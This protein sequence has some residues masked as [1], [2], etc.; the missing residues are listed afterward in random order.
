MQRPTP[1]GKQ[2]GSPVSEVR[3]PTADVGEA[4][5]RATTN[6]HDLEGLTRPLL[7]ALAKLGSFESTYLTVFDWERREQEV[8]VVHSVGKIQVEEGMRVAIPQS[9]S[10]EA[11]PGVT[12][13]PVDL[14]KTSPDSWVA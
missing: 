11:L 14:S 12:R 10:Q 3:F 1:T 5:L 8:R 7:E 6:G 9:L 4:L 13:S 2:R